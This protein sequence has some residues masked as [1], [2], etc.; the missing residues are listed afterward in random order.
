MLSSERFLR[1]NK[2]A[3]GACRYMKGNCFM[4]RFV[5]IDEISDGKLYTADDLVKAD[6]FG[7]K[8]KTDQ[9]ISE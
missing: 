1:D 7:C 9:F 3:G 5:M 4:E 8:G 2:R 6:A